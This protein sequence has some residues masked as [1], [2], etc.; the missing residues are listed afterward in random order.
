MTEVLYSELAG[1][2]PLLSPPGHYVEEAA[3]LL[4]RLPPAPPD[5]RPTLLELGCGG[6]SLAWHLKQRFDAT[7]TDR[8]PA[9]LAV[10][11]AVNPEC[12]HVEADM[13]HLRLGRR[14]DLV[15][16]HDAIM[17]ATEPDDVR[18]AL[19]TAALHCLRDGAVAVLPD[20]VKET[21]APGHES[22]GE[23]GEDGRG[24]RYLAWSFDP[25]PDDDIP[26]ARGG[27]DGARREGPARRGPVRTRS[28]ARLVL[29]GRPRCNQRRRPMGPRSV[30]RPADTIALRPYERDLEEARTMTARYRSLQLGLVD[31]VVMALAIRRRAIATLDVRHFA[32]VKLPGHVRLLPRDL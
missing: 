6:G 28:L 32:A 26:A 8:A 4:G 14:F 13:R 22:G 16:I 27:R 30:H 15:L 31:A 2:W 5:R 3:D 29:R 20:F 24:L 17:H 11:R 12:E 10:S 18:A 7:L 23:D 9:M 21:F 25:D 1:W 19:R